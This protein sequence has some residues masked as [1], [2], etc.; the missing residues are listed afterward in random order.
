[1][2]PL[3][4]PTAIEFHTP[5]ADRYAPILTPEAIA[6]L[7]TLQREFN[8][9]RKQLLAARITRQAAL[10]AGTLPNF[11]PET[12]SIRQASWTIAP[13]PPTSKTAAS[14]SQA[15]STAR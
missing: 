7:T 15:Q 1:M 3:S 12:L 6:F 14:K 4:L 10:D 13:L 8:P 5:L 11:L 2:S 9:R